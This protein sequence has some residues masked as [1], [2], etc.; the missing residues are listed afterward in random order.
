MNELELAEAIEL[1]DFYQLKIEAI[2]AKL[3]VRVGSYSDI[4]EHETLSIRV[5]DLNLKINGLMNR[6]RAKSSFWRKLFKA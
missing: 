3:D 1:R 4:L 6:R 5:Y 2:E